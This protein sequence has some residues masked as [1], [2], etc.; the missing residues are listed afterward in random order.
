MVMFITRFVVK[1]PVEEFE[2]LFKEHS[3]FM[4]SQPGFV[5]FQMVRSMSDPHVYLNIGQWHSP[6]DHGR[7]TSD[8]RF[9]QHARAMRDLVDVE[10]DMYTP[11]GAVG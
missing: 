11:V 3:E 9:Q 6:E 2:R 5:D 1:G 8:P 7:V 4:S 10:A